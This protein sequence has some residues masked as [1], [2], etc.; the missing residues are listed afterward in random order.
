MDVNYRDQQRFLENLVKHAF[1]L[2]HD[3]KNLSVYSFSGLDMLI[4]QAIAQN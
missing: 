4:W 3:N 1:E 2:D